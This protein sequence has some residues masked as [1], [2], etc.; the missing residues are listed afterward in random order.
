MGV[1][2]NSYQMYSS[3]TP[4]LEC[5]AQ[6]L[7]LAAAAE[8][9]TRHPLADAVLAEA[10]RRGLPVA[11]CSSSVTEPGHGV[12]AM[13]EGQQVGAAGGLPAGLAGHS[14]QRVM[15]ACSMQHAGCSMKGC[16]MQHARPSCMQGRPAC[17]EAT[18]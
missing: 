6:V 16:G 11:S 15:L 5:C 1:L 8:A 13:V 7:A 4:A 18:C 2:H 17:S 14:I 9:T 3:L 12:V 10:Q